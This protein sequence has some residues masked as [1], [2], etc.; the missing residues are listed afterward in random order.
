MDRNKEMKEFGDIGWTLETRTKM[1]KGK[2]ADI[3]EMWNGALGCKQEG[4]SG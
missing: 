3:E 1:E 4:V 2:G